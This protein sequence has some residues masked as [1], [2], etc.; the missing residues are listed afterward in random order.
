MR[1][2]ILEAIATD[3]ARLLRDLLATGADPA[4]E[5][6]PGAGDSPVHVAANQGKI[7]LLTLLLDEWTAST[8]DALAASDV[9]W[10]TLFHG[11]VAWL[12]EH[13]ADPT[14]RDDVWDVT[15]VGRARHGDHAAVLD[16]F[17]RYPDRLTESDR[18]TLE[19]G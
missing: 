9:L 19:R 1:E 15:P 7:E 14:I 10:Q 16:V 18:E 6:R 17:R 11:Q 12:L 5:S 4:A 13:G 3:D 2:K 8:P